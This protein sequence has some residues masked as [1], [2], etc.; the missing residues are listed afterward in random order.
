M[1]PSL[2]LIFMLYASFVPIL[3]PLPPLAQFLHVSAVLSWPAHQ[4]QTK[5]FSEEFSERATGRVRTCDL[6]VNKS[7]VVPL[8]QHRQ[9]P[10][11][12]LIFAIYAVT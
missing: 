8:S 1:P 6:A 2:I 12:F 4:R 3:K 11:K 5:N 9:L 10:R 7:K